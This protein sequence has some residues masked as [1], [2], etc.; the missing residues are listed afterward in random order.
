VNFWKRKVEY[1]RLHHPDYHAACD[2]A[3]HVSKCAKELHTH[4]SYD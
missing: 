4:S 2:H 1:K 3:Y